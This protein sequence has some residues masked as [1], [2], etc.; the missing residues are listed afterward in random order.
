MEQTIKIRLLGSIG[1]IYEESKDCKLESAFFE[2]A[3]NELTELSN[4][5]G[6]SS[7]QSLLVAMVF[8]LITKVIGL[9]SMI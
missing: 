7:I 2:K 3:T 8:S 5:F 6:I 9:I 1:K 4:Y